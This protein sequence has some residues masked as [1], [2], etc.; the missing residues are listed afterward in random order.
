MEP[1]RSD[2]RRHAR[3]CGWD[4]WAEI[5]THYDADP[6]D[7]LDLYGTRLC[8]YAVKRTTQGALARP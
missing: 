7:A 6:D 8:C 5:A 4:H 3:L 1:H 2:D